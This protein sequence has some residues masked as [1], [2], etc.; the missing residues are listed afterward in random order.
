MT[1]GMGLNLPLSCGQ[2]WVG[3]SQCP[4]T[5]LCCLTLIQNITN[6]RPY[7]LCLFLTV[8]FLFMVLFSCRWVCWSA[9]DCVVIHGYTAAHTQFLNPCWSRALT[10]DDYSFHL[11][12]LMYKPF[13][14]QAK[15]M[16]RRLTGVSPANGLLIEKHSSIQKTCLQ[17][18]STLQRFW[19][20]LLLEKIS[21]ICSFLRGSCVVIATLKC[22][23]NIVCP[24]VGSTTC[25]C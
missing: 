1:S 23:M 18:T 25:D 3:L 13:W 22:D 15:Q 5:H 12:F 4:S 21:E 17:P 14:S 10:C 9:K 6:A 19:Q 24:R 2:V 16:I 11:L 7:L 20:I 8:A